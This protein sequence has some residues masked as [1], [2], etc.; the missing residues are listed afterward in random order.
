LTLYT[1][2]RASD[3]RDGPDEPYN[4]TFY[5]ADPHG[6]AATSQL[7][8]QRRHQHQLLMLQRQHHHHH[9]HHADNLTTYPPATDDESTAVET[10]LYCT[11][12]RDPYYSHSSPVLHYYSQNAASA[13]IKCLDD[14]DRMQ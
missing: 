12:D 3:E 8:Q 6:I 11:A 4:M 2:A 13:A 1:C 14:M 5:G 10:D 9:L 7:L